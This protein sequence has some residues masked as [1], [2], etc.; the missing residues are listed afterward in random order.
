MGKLR[1]RLG[2][3]EIELEGPDAFISK[4]LNQFYARLGATLISKP[5]IK[6]QILSSAPHGKTG[7]KAPTPAEF[8]KQKKKTDGV[9]QI[10]IFGKYLEQ[11]RNKSEF[12]RKDINAITTEAKFSKDIH[13]QYFTNAVKQG[14][15]R[16]QGQN[17]SLTLSAEELL[18][19]I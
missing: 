16:K 1:I 18:A 19:T 14:L 10:L 17:Y 5:A 2:G 11:Y 6:E 12:T 4:Q 8:Y 13:A 9:S 3:N 7:G 15:L